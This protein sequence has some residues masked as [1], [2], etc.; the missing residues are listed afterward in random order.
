MVLHLTDIVI[1]IGMPSS[2]PLARR[3]KGRDVFEQMLM[4]GYGAILR[5]SS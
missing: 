1:D 4:R 5:W 3:C 2:V